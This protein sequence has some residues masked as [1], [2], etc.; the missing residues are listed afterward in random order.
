[1]ATGVK[2]PALCFTARQDGTDRLM[3]YC[4]A[5]GDRLPYVLFPG[6]DGKEY[7]DDDAFIIL[8]GS[9]HVYSQAREFLPLE[10]IE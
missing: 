7:A 3:F 9:F 5:M 6:S 2:R 4:P 1:M 10:P 8:A